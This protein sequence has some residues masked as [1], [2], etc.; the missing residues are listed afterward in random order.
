MPRIIGELAH[1]AALAGDLTAAR[2]A[3][4]EV[5]HYT[6]DGA[7]LFHLWAALAR[8][9]EAAARGERSTAIRLA[10]AL[11]EQAQLRGQ[12]TFQLQAL[13]DVARLG[14]ASQVS[15]SLR[16]AAVGVEGQLAPLYVSHATALDAQD[17]TALDQ[18]AS[19]FAALG[20]NLLAAEADRSGPTDLRRTR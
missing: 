17:G 5:E 12:V 14:Q 15:S 6:A 3:L 7:R 10:M 8:P 2:A 19:G 9:W 16:E 18:I 13:H 20:V 1:A 4:E 11:A